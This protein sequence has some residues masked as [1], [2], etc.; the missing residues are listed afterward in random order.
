MKKSIIVLALLAG[1]LGASNHALADGTTD[2]TN[3][4]AQQR[5]EAK[6]AL[7]NVLDNT[8][9][10]SWS[11]TTNEWKGKKHEYTQGNAFWK[12]ID[13]Q[14]IDV[15]DGRGKGR[16]VVLLGKKLDTGWINFDFDS[17]MVLS[18]RGNT[19]RQNGYLDDL[20]LALKNWESCSFAF[21]DSMWVIGYKTAT[22]L[23]AKMWVYP[24][25]LKVLKTES[26]ENGKTV[27]RY[28][29]KDIKYNPPLDDDLWDN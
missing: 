22:G 28:E 25:S 17:K 10:M 11:H 27:E 5:A 20:A 24:G 14:R 9:T 21:E 1:V 19:V 12:G 18:L 8:K 15:T 7:Q 29:Y 26:Y 4:L 16:T 23:D 2:T 3:G 6:L 13:L